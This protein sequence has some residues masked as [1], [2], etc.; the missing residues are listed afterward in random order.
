MYNRTNHFLA[1]LRPALVWEGQLPAS[2]VG[3][4]QSNNES[5]VGQ[6]TQLLGGRW[7]HCAISH[8]FCCS[9]PTS[10][11]FQI[12][13]KQSLI[14]NAFFSPTGICTFILELEE[15]LAASKD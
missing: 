6:G 5:S 8:T 4:E 7:L 14:R 11:D 9:A 10:S 15:A 13:T 2:A 3:C 12:Q 1:Y